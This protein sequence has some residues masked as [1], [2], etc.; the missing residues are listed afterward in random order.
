LA[1][2]NYEIKGIKNIIVANSI[3]NVEINFNTIQTL[4]EAQN[5]LND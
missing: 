2:R 4:F 3:K 5:F 1:P